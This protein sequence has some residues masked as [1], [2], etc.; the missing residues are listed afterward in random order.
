MAEE[1]RFVTRVNTTAAYQDFCGGEAVIDRVH[2]TGSFREE[3]FTLTPCCFKVNGHTITLT[4]FCVLLDGSGTEE[5]RNL[6]RR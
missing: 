6:R 4:D 1:G 3:Q 5:T 2:T